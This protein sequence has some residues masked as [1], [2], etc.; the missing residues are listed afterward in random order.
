MSHVSLPRDLSRSDISRRG[1]LKAAGTATVLVGAGTSVLTSAVAATVAPP[2]SSPESLVKV[3][4]GSLTPEQRKQICFAWDHQDETRGLL[5]TRISANWHV[6]TPVIDSDFYTADQ[7][8]LIREIFV[9]LIQPDWVTRL[10]RQM[11]D[12]EDGFGKQ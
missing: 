8:R 1:F 3:L 12:D 2:N 7:R 9:G 4:Y 11:K 5:R 6:T 10:D